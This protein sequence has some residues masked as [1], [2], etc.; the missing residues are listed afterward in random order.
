MKQKDK[1][2]TVNMLIKHINQKDK[3]CTIN[4]LIKHINQKDKMCTIYTNKT[5]KSEG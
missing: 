5:Y 4:I 1:M 2:Y 3:M